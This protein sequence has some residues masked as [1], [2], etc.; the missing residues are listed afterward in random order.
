MTP[1][2]RFE[3]N[4]KVCLSF[5]AFHPELWQPAWGIR[6]ILEALISFLPTPADGA[7][8]AIDWSPKERQA[9][10]KKSVNWECP[11]CGKTADLLPKKKESSDGEK[12]P[13]RFQKQIEELQ[14]L[15]MIEHQKE[16]DD[17]EDEKN[18]TDKE[19]PGT[20]DGID[21]NMDAPEKPGAVVDTDG[22]ADEDTA[23]ASTENTSEAA[24]V[25]SA[26]PV[27]DEDEPLLVTEPPV[28]T[29]PQIDDEPPALRERPL[30]VR[31]ELP[32]QVAVP[33]REPFPLYDDM[34]RFFHPFLQIVMI[35]FAV[36]CYLL[37]QKLQRLVE[38]LDALEQEQSG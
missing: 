32:P 4:T 30:M 6:L 20:V 16:D 35:L 38:E 18:G 31:T 8:G 7:I 23:P 12:K 26:N 37:V 19:K 21:T 11:L 24:P 14:R 27:D 33:P 10:A 13:S 1:T 29:P 3:T 9:L 25:T 34:L 15:Q 17:D 2:G 22:V 36:L 28:S 5:S